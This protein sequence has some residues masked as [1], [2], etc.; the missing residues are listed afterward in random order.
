[1]ADSPFMDKRIESMA[2]GLSWTF[3]HARRYR[4][5]D[6]VQTG[7]LCEDE[8]A[9]LGNWNVALQHVT[10]LAERCRK[11][12]KNPLAIRLGITALASDA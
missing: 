2:A 12:G 11:L 9:F 4:A 6:T 5:S 3:E 1:M 7:N 10:V 8:R